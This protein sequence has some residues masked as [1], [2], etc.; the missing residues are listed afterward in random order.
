MGNRGPW[1]PMRLGSSFGFWPWFFFRLWP[2]FLFSADF[3]YGRM[4]WWLQGTHI[5]VL[6]LIVWFCLIYFWIQ[7]HFKNKTVHMREYIHIWKIAQINLDQLLASFTILFVFQRR[8]FE[9]FRI[10]WRNF[11]K[12]SDINKNKNITALIDFEFEQ[13]EIKKI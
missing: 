3:I 2:P 8:N 12:I 10:I 7:W 11:R 9:F 6:I 1:G 4:F 13:E 5:S